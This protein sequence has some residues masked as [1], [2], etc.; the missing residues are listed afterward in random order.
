MYDT[1]GAYDINVARTA[2]KID[3]QLIYSNVAMAGEA[4]YLAQAET[5]FKSDFK[6][7][8]IPEYY[9][10]LLSLIHI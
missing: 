6:K 1:T 5:Y 3:P 9:K 7:G 2:L 10:L 4:P 8:S